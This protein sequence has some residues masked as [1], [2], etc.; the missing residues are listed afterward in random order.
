VPVRRH[1]I[2]GLFFAADRGPDLNVP[3]FSE[4]AER[5][6]CTLLASLRLLEAV[7]RSPGPERL[8]LLLVPWLRTKKLTG[9]GSEH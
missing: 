6:H 8:A 7:D 5:A 4:I 1:D 2:D 9:T 3:F